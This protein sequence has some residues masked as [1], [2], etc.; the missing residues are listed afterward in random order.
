MATYLNEYKPLAN[1]MVVNR[2]SIAGTSLIE[3]E[4]WEPSQPSSAG[5][6]YGH[7]TITHIEERL[8]GRVGSSDLPADL[9]ALPYGKERIERVKA[10]QEAEYQR[11]YEAIAQ[12]YPKLDGRR[13]MGSLSYSEN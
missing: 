4:V 5:R 11:A 13:N 10:W 7:S 3:I 1:G 12:A 8:Y 6:F 2:Y 9:D